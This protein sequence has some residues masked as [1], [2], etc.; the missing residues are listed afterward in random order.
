LQGLDLSG[1]QG[2]GKL[3]PCR[4]MPGASV[5]PGL[6]IGADT[7]VRPFGKINHPLEGKTSINIWKL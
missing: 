2:A 7:W 1:P 4:E 3:R 6:K 5:R